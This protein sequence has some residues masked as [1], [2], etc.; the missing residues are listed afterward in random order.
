MHLT[1]EQILQKRFGQKLCI[2]RPTLIY[3]KEDNHLGYGPNQ[4][5]QKSREGKSITLFGK[6]E[7]KREK[8]RKKIS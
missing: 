4:F 2:L 3:G 7:E 5:Y 8:G 6:G 1:R